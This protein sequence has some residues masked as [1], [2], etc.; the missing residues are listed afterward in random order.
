M[1][2]GLHPTNRC[3]HPRPKD[4]PVQLPHFGQVD[5]TVGVVIDRQ[6]MIGDVDRRFGQFDVLNGFK[7]AGGGESQSLDVFIADFIVDGLVDAVFGQGLS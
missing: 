6:A 5:I 3:Q 7:L 1:A 2:D 4:R